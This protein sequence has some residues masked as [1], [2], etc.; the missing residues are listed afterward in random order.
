MKSPESRLSLDDL[1]SYSSHRRQVALQRQTLL[2]FPSRQVR[3]I[4]LDHGIFAL[5]AG[6]KVT[7]KVYRK[8]EAPLPH[9]WICRI[10]RTIMHQIRVH[11]AKEIFESPSSMIKLPGSFIKL[12][13][14]LRLKYHVWSWMVD[15]ASKA[16]SAESLNQTFPGSA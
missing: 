15:V 12:R 6:P 8:H 13:R 9:G 4:P 7:W 3:A 10:F 14:C 16:L 5:R 1:D 11:M 2:Y